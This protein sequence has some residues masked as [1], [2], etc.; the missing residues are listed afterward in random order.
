MILAISITSSKEMLPL[1]LM[2]FTFLRSLSGSFRALITNAAA[3][4][5]TATLACLFWTVSFTVTLKPFQSFAVSLA[6]SSPIFFGESPR[7]P[8]LGAKEEAAP[9]SPPVT[10]T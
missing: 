7:G 4:G 2:F 10:R 1:C 3:D 9:T 6:I 8:I 5:T